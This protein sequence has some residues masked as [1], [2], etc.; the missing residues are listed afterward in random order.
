[1]ENELQQ[2]EFESNRVRVYMCD[3]APW[4]VAVDVCKALQIKN[5]TDA[6]KGLASDERAA[7]VLTEGSQRRNYNIVS[8]SGMYALIMRSRS[9]VSEP[10]R[11]WV[12]HDV[13]PS[14]RRTGVYSGFAAAGLLPAANQ[15]LVELTRRMN[16][17]IRWELRRVM[18]C[19]HLT[20]ADL[21]RF[22]TEAGADPGTIGGYDWHRWDTAEPTQADISRLDLISTDFLTSLIEMK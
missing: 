16:S 8:E 13:L 14:I 6:L 4:F 19:F 15:R 9:K 7:L 17:R 18:T 3:N 5:T 12:T 1:M 22:A 2:F 21:V 11:R 10:F 20:S